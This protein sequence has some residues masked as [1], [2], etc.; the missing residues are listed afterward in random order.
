MADELR[1]RIIPER[2]ETDPRAAQQAAV[3]AEATGPDGLSEAEATRRRARFGANAIP[4]KRP[5]K[6][7]EFARK[8]WGPIAWMLEAAAL[9]QILLGKS[10]EAAIIL[11]LLVVNAAIG[12]IEE[13][14]ASRALAL[15]RQRL[16]A[17]A[18]VR[19]DGAWRTVPASDLVPGDLVH[20]RMGDLAP[21]DIAIGEGSVLLDQSALT[22]ESIP[23]EAGPGAR[24][25]AAAIVRRGEATGVVTATGQAT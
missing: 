3:E 22:G 5:S 21:A 18:R 2:D 11:A 14:R 1:D 19:R 16:V 9:L 15:L 13:G 12:F 8:F 7:L 20:M 24:A 10:G 23:V 17:M 25:Y 4:E 6:T